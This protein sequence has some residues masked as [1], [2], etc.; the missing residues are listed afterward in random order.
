MSEE[1][2]SEDLILEAAEVET[3]Y[4]DSHPLTPSVSLMLRIISSQLD[5]VEELSM[6]LDE[7][8]KAPLYDDLHID[9]LVICKAALKVIRRMQDRLLKMTINIPLDD[10]L[11]TITKTNKEFSQPQ[12]TDTDET[13]A[14]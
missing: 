2:Q 8:S 13:Q 7:E 4:I 6:P 14:E 10:R 12:V 9:K 1:T 3:Q 5:I 11:M